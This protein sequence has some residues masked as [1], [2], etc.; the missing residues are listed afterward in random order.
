MQEK[1][2]QHVRCIEW[3]H[4]GE[5]IF[6]GFGSGRL[7]Q[8]NVKYKDGLMNH[9]P[10]NPDQYGSSIVQLSASENLL[11]VSTLERAFIVDIVTHKFSQVRDHL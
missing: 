3:N 2:R 4:N 1:S 6:C 7:V 10:L 5:D 9:V 11:L 8:F